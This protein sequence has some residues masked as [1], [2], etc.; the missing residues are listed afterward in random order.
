MGRSDLSRLV[1]V[2]RLSLAM[3]KVLLLLFFVP[4]I[5]GVILGVLEFVSFECCQIKPML[6]AAIA[7]ALCLLVVG[8]ASVVAKVKF[9]Q[10]WLPL[11]W[12]FVV[13]FVLF[14]I[15]SVSDLSLPPLLTSNAFLINTILLLI[16][17]G[18]WILIR[19][20]RR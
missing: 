10:P 16:I 7:I 17:F 4:L 8:A 3:K 9:G 20:K 6:P 15:L 13:V 14:A 12:T 2:V 1:R 18:I 5:V 11:G 19:A